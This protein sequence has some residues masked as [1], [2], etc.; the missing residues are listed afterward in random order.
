MRGILCGK[1][2][3]KGQGHEEHVIVATDDNSLVQIVLNGLP[4]S[5]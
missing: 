3:N 1:F 5:Y 4:D 2:S